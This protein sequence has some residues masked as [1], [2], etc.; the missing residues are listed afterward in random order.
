MA[1]HRLGW[2]NE[3][4]HIEDVSGYFETKIAAFAKH[5]SQLTEVVAFFGEFL[6][7]EA[8]ELGERIS[9]SHAEDFRV[10]DLS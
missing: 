7:K 4:N 8:V 10:L 1:R 9:A 3:S 6:A 5:E 2:T